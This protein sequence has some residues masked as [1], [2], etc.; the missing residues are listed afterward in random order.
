[1]R[2]ADILGALGRSLEQAE[3]IVDA[4]ETD[5]AAVVSETLGAAYGVAH[6]SGATWLA[7]R[8]EALTPAGRSRNWVRAGDGSL[9]SREA[10]VAELV[11]EGLT[12]REIATRLF[13]SIR[14]VTSHL[15]HIYTKLGLSLREALTA[16][17][18][19]D[20]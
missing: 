5:P 10:E 2:A 4:A 14:T 8:I 9:T 19:A 6:H 12:N 16:W 15:D 17:Q 11:A 20:S 1:L 7:S 13:I 3:R 18:R